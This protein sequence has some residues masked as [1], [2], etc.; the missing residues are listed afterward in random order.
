MKPLSDEVICSNAELARAYLMWLKGTRGRASSTAYSYSR[1]LQQY[2]DHIEDTPL[3]RVKL[4]DME[5]YVQRNRG[6]RARGSQGSAATQS[7]EGTSRDV[8]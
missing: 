8:V 4:H 5:A 2:L 1:V 3:A 6:G 7:R